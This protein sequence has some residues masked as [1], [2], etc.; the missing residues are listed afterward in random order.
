MIELP[1]PA[2][3]VRVGGRIENDRLAAADFVE[4]EYYLCSRADYLAK[5]GW[6][7]HKEGMQ[8]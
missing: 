6:A 7:L 3:A 8:G 2:Y 5:S 4:R 1:M